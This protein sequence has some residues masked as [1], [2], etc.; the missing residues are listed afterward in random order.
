MFSVLVLFAT[1]TVGSTAPY[2]PCLDIRVCLHCKHR[3]YGFIDNMLVM[4]FPAFDT[5][6]M[7]AVM[8]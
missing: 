4:G 3:N 2:P 6:C 7:S 5:T 1:C 8:W